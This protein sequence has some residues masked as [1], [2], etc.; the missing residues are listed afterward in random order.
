MGS[1]AEI[2]AFFRN[3]DRCAAQSRLRMVT[4]YAQRP[5]ELSDEDFRNIAASIEWCYENKD[6]QMVI[7]LVTPL[8]NFFEQR[9][10][11]QEGIHL[12][13]LALQA[14]DCVADGTGRRPQLCFWLGLLY[15]RQGQLTEAKQHYRTSAKLA[16]QLGQLNILADACHRLGWAAHSRRKFAKAKRLY[17]KAKSI[18]EGLHPPDPLALSRSWHQLGILEQD[19]GHYDLARSNHEK[20]LE[21]RRRQPALYLVAASLHQLGALAVEQKAWGEAERHFQEALKIRRSLDDRAGEA[22]ALDQLGVIAQRQNR[23]DEAYQY[24]KDGLTLKEKHHDTAGLIRTEMHLGEICLAQEK[25]AIARDWFE[26]CLKES[27]AL[28]EPY[29]EAHACLQ[30]GFLALLAPDY[31][32]AEA[33]Y[34][35]GYDLLT[36]L[37]GTG[38][39]QAGILYQLGLIAFEQNQYPLA[40]KRLGASLQI[41]ERESLAREVARTHLQLGIVYQAQDSYA[42]ARQHYATSYAMLEKEGGDIADQVEALYRLGNIAELSRQPGEADRYYRQVV[43]LCQTHQLKPMGG[44]AA[45]LE[46]VEKSLH[47]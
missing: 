43:A 36:K 27:Q 37:D 30:L 47:K 31:E 6:W 25:W 35:H 33:Y 7:D 8:S 29:F 10:F 38:R 16:F 21:L 11:W 15:D 39:E 9:R 45:A 26:H 44:L 3:S 2:Q 14:A 23:L 32:Q 41:Q 34:Q 17:E 46:R 4:D 20:A 24:Y 5:H 22:Q 28:A 19:L 13:T 1:Q 18:R 12:I 42:M 40:L